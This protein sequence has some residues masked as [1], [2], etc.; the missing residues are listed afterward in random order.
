MTD[1]AH[2]PVYNKNPW[3]SQGHEGHKAQV[4]GRTRQETEELFKKLTAIF[5]DPS[6]EETLRNVLANH[7]NER[8]IERLSNYCM[9]VLF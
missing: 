5:P 6:Q 2:V 3:R 8:D 1:T 9:S 7:E 4:W